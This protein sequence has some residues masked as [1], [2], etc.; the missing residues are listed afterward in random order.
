MGD[1]SAFRF[2]RMIAIDDDAELL[3][4]SFSYDNLRAYHL[5]HWLVRL[6]H[7]FTSLTKVWEGEM[8][9]IITAKELYTRFLISF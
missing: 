2:G 6:I 7:H 9:M 8:E 1:F 3:R 5:G 4:I